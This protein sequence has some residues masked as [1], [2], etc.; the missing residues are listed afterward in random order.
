MKKLYTN[1]NSLYTNYGSCTSYV[2]DLNVDPDNLLDSDS[3]NLFQGV[4]L[5]NQF[6]QTSSN[7]RD[8]MIWLNQANGEDRQYVA[9]NNWNNSAA[10]S[11]D[12]SGIMPT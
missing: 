10:S 6:F 8:V 11:F 12:D 9:L 3:K 7:T 1:S 4:L 5:A 2:D